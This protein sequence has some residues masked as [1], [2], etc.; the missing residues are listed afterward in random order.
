MRAGVHA[1]VADDIDGDAAVGEIGQDLLEHGGLVDDGPHR[2]RVV[3]RDED[4]VGEGRV[5]DV[6][7]LDVVVERYVALGRTV[8]KIIFL[9]GGFGFILWFDWD[10]GFKK[11]GRGK[12]PS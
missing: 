5:T 4:E 8:K 10:S 11:G 7:A 2:D 6:A 9:G 12:I 1:R 3:A